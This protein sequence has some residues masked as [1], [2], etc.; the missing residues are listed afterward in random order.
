MRMSE[1]ESEENKAAA[2][3]QSIHRGK[4]AREEQEQK[5][6]AAAKI[7]SI[8]R[9]KATR[10][11]KKREEKEITTVGNN[12]RIQR[13]IATPLETKMK[14]EAALTL[15]L[16][17]S[18]ELND[19]KEE[20]V[21]QSNSDFNNTA[22]T[23]FG[24]ETRQTDFGATGE[25]EIRGAA[26]TNFNNTQIEKFSTFT[27][28]DGHFTGLYPE[29]TDALL[30]SPRDPLP[31]QQAQEDLLVTVGQDQH[32]S[33]HSNYKYVKWFARKSNSVSILRP[34]FL[35]ILAVLVVKFIY[36]NNDECCCLLFVVCF[37]DPLSQGR[38]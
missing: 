34:S 25:D 30:T 21:P 13:G 19:N 3:I 24:C 16:Q 14:E 8:Q 26:D 32:K 31:L 7:Q 18:A 35:M 12:Q 10:S 6:K 28:K 5:Q 15:K 4:A 17:R 29:T 2:K 22:G 38:I 23:N 9:G 1:I 11:N 36:S 37:Q 20:E 33:V 27:K